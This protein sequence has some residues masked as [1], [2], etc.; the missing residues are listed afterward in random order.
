[1][2][3]YRLARDHGTRKQARA[4]RD[5]IYLNVAFQLQTQFGP[6]SVLYLP[7]P[8]RSLGAF[9]AAN[10]AL[11]RADLF[12]LAMCFSG[13]YDPASWNG[14][15]ERGN[16]TYFNNPLDYI[17][18]LSGD[19]LGWLR[20]QVS[21]LLVC[22]QGQWEDTTGALESTRRFATLLSSKGIRCELDLWGYDVPHDWPSWRAQLA[23]HLPRF[24]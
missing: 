5:T 21:L 22:G 2:S 20:G 1:M 14:W 19:H 9:H 12:P 7:N 4:I 17:V 15:G 11:K 10:F 16:E 8:A 18:N 24:C 13:N 3:A 23:H 6:E